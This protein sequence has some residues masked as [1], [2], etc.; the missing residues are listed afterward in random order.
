[1]RFLPASQDAGNRIGLSTISQSFVELCS[2]LQQ[3]V[4]S[5]EMKTNLGPRYGTLIWHSIWDPDLGP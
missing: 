5:L 1:V 2:T 4:T 3:K